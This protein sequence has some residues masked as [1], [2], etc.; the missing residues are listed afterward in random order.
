MTGDTSVRK[1]DDIGGQEL[2]YAEVKAIAS[3]NPAVLTLAEADAEIQRLTVLRKAYMDEQYLARRNLRDLPGRIEQ[4]MQR[5]NGLTADQ[6]TMK[7]HEADLI[8]IGDRAVADKDAAGYL[9]DR[10]DALPRFVMQTQRVPLGTYRGLEFGMVLHPQWTPEV[11]LEGTLIRQ[12]RLLREHQGPRAVLNALERLTRGYSPECART[13]QE[14]DIAQGQLRDYQARTNQPFAQEPYLKELEE[15][16]DRLRVGLSG[17]APAEGAPTV[18]ELAERIKAL[19]SAHAVEA[20]PERT[21]KRR[22]SAEEPVT[23]RISRRMEPTPA[24]EGE[25]RRKLAEET[26]AGT[27]R[28]MVPG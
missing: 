9:S 24:G 3:G 15:L 20:A 6:A 28:A 18:P 27:A 2:S 12:D 10:M 19:K 17:A 21:A 13:R 5:L 25:W 4:L 14:L 16:R 11:Y 22:V 8:A 26:S 1:A 23:A 7:A